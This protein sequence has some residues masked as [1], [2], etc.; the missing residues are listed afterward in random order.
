MTANLLEKKIKNKKIKKKTPAQSYQYTRQVWL[1]NMLFDVTVF[2]FF[3]QNFTS[4]DSWNNAQKALAALTLTMSGICLE[5]MQWV[6]QK[7]NVDNT[8]ERKNKPGFKG[9]KPYPPLAVNVV[10]LWQGVNMLYLLPS[11]ILVCR[12]CVFT[13]SYF[14]SITPRLSLHV[15]TFFNKF[16]P[17]TC[18]ASGFYPQ[19]YPCQYCWVCNSR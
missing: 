18:I 14:F 1:Q 2:H 5:K 3:T 4:F 19:C 8:G 7:W 11:F 15:R 17:K 13:K 9:T 10:T 12:V 6:G 16:I